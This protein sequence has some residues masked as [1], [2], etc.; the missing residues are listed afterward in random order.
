MKPQRQLRIKFITTC[1]LL[2]FA[3]NCSAQEDFT[4]DERKYYATVK[5]LLKNFEHKKYDSTQRAEVFEKF[6]YFDNILADTSKAKINE[7]IKFF[8]ALFPR[9]FRFV[10]SVGI[11]NLDARPTRLFKTDTAYFQHFDKKGELEDLLPFA[12]TFYYKKTPQIPLGTLLFEPKTHKLLAWT[13]INQGGYW[14]FL[15]FNLF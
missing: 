3:C 15:T 7:R 5:S 4:P 14:Y 9:V 1:L 12:I 6:V 8:D 11:E 2:A 10:D 13:I